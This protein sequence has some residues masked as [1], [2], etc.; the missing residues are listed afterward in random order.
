MIVHRV[1]RT[2][3]SSH[4]STR[5]CARLPIGDPFGDVLYGPMLSARF[6]ARFE[7]YLAW[8]QPH[9]R[10]LGSSGTGRITADNP[11]D[12][13]VGD[14]SAGIFYHPVIVADV[15]PDDA[16]FREETFGP[17]IGVTTYG[18]LD[19]AIQLANLPGYGLSSSIYTRDPAEAFRF[20]RGI[21]G[22]HGQHQQLHLG[23]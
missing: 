1:S 20:R 12:G 6:A 21:C 11:R 18:E 7:E 5:P 14:P 2:T 3:S 8:I 9:H 22:R 19:E 13:F 4:G 16:I 17:L 10:V 15:R 23:R